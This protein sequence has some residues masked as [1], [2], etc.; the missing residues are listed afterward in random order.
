MSEYFA[1]IEKG[2]LLMVDQFEKA[3]VQFFAARAIK[4]PN[5]PSALT[6]EKF[7]LAENEITCWDGY[8]K[9]PLV[10]LDGLSRALDLGSIHYKN[11]GP[12]FGLGSFK[13]LGGAY[14]VM[15]LLQR[16][17]AKSSGK[18]VSLA[19]IRK[20]TFA[21]EAAALTVISATDGNHGRSVAWGAA[22]FGARCRIYIHAEV[23][24]YRAQTIRMLGAEVIRLDGDYDA[25]VAQTRVDAEKYGWH[26]VSDTSWEG[27]TQTPTEVMAG[28]GVMAREVVRDLPTAPTHVFLQGGVGGLAAAVSKSFHDAWGADAPRVFLV[29]P[30]LAPCLY[31]SA[32]AGAMTAVDIEAE[33]IM[34]GLSCGVPSAVAWPV[35]SALVSGFI[36]IP[37]HVVAPAVRMLANGNAT[38]HRI[39]AGESAVAGLCGLICAATQR[40]LRDA[41]VLNEDARIVLIGSE[42][43]TDPTVF[44]RLLADAS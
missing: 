11:E 12:R 37:E 21:E 27:Y 14:A 9:T 15:L 2:A 1:I 32:A 13:A 16:E 43:V 36:T 33:T 5:V 38:N 41:I 7:D 39:E 35:L 6:R 30:E 40:D 17:I 20:K 26:I 3:N 22:R 42:G 19:E 18:P 44:N 25:A 31:A 29:E 28:Y 10:P 23:S 8:E 34:A 24:E 4:E